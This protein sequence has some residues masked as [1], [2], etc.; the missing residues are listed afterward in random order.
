MPYAFV[1]TNL[2]DLRAEPSNQSER[3]SQLFFADTVEILGEDAGFSNIRQAD[4]YRGWAD[5]RFL[6]SV[7]ANSAVR[8]R[9]A[10]NAVIGVPQ[11]RLLDVKG[12]KSMPPYFLYYGT[13]VHLSSRRGTYV[14]IST[15]DLKRFRI[16]ASA[17]GLIDPKRVQ[18]LSGASLVREAK[19]F[20]GVP[21]LWGGISPAGFDC[22]GLVRTV[23]ARFGLYLPRDT[24]D[25]IEV[26]R[27]IDRSDVRTGDLLFF[28]RHV[29]FAIGTNQI[30]HASRGGGG[31]RIN[32]LV[33]GAL[34][35]RPDLDHDFQEAR[36]ILK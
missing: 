15:P 21:Y 1:T 36:R 34:N 8:V 30:I 16:K 32:S 12:T 13:P 23:C 28:K 6:A 18:S 25:Q 33:A 22:S 31:V 27:H 29:G 17:L 26:G 9:Q 7:P 35:Y 2:L 20:L 5:S 19:R 4:G 10:L 11:A 14:I 24:K 3:L